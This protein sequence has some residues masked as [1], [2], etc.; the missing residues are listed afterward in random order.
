MDATSPFS[1]SRPPRGV[2]TIDRAKRRMLITARPGFAGTTLSRATA[3]LIREEPVVASYDFV[4]D[5]TNSDTGASQADLDIVLGAYHSV[6]REVGPKFGCYVTTDP[7]FHIWTAS[8]DELFGDRQCLTF[9]AFDDAV[10]FLDRKRDEALERFRVPMKG[11]DAP[12]K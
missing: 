11:P 7:H 3:Q 6:P 5:I 12:G 1:P 9:G 8:M 10:T 2:F 4:L